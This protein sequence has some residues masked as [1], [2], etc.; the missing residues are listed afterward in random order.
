MTARV[1]DTHQAPKYSCGDCEREWI[2]ERRAQTMA[3]TEERRAPMSASPTV[4]HALSTVDNALEALQ[5]AFR[6]KNKTHQT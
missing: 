5:K 2:V 1:G 3:V 6:S 4:V